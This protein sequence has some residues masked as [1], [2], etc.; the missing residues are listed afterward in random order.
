MQTTNKKAT[1]KGFTDGSKF[2]F[3]IGV[4]GSKLRAFLWIP[5]YFKI[6]QGI[7]E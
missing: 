2:R 1:C 3:G 7:T 6:I 5:N 4:T